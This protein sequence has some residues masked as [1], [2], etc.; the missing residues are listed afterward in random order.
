MFQP[1]YLE[2]MESVGQTP[3]PDAVNR[4]GERLDSRI[5]G[6]PT[7]T[8]LVP[9]QTYKP[10]RR[11]REF[12]GP[13]A[14]EFFVHGE[15]GIRFSDALEGN[16]GGFER[17]DDR[18]LFSDDRVQII[19]RLRV[20]LAAIARAQPRQLTFPSGR[21]MPTLAIKGKAEYAFAFRLVSYAF[22]VPITNHSAKRQPITRTKLAYEVAKSVRKFL[23]V[24]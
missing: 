5:H 24:R 23:E 8:G 21:R 15:K 19:I 18:S 3:D 4:G 1:T 7:P 20:R 17:R 9:Q 12:K 14:I 2:Y 11:Q 13:Q 10:A 6:C 22:K 16:W